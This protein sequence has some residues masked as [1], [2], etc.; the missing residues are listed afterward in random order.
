[1]DTKK[2]CLHGEIATICQECASGYSQNF[3]DWSAFLQMVRSYYEPDKPKDWSFD[4]LAREEG[5]M[6]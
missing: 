5:V 2:Y 3:P 4:Q 6:D 1:M